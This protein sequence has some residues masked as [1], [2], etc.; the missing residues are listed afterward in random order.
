MAKAGGPYTIIG[1]KG[2]QMRDHICYISDLTRFKT[3]YPGWQ[4]TVSL[5]QILERLVRSGHA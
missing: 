2:K 1:Y 5:R 3:H 4:I